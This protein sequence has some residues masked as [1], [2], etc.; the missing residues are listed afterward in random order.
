MLLTEYGLY[1]TDST[2][3]KL[4]AQHGSQRVKN[5]TAATSL[6]HEEDPPGLE[7]EDTHRMKRKDGQ[8]KHVQSNKNEKRLTNFLR[9][10][11]AI[12]YLFYSTEISS[13][14]DI[15]TELK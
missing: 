8:K 10:S 15:W 12:T 1:T 2:T 6:S 14:A 3:P 11:E 7:R 4:L 13:K 9:N 5:K